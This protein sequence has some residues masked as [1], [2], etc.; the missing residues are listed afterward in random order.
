MT[1]QSLDTHP[2]AERIMVNMI[3]KASMSKRFRLVQSLTQSALW[4]SLHAWQERHQ[5][6]DEREAAIRYIS[7]SC[8]PA[9]A[10]SV[11]AA[12][13]RRECW[14]IQPADLVTAMLPALKIFD[15]L[16]IP[17]YLGGSV[18]SSLHGMQQLA[19]DIDLI[20]DLPE[21]QL[22]ALL[23]LLGHHYV[24]DIDMARQAMQERASFPLIHLDSLMKI[25][26]IL[27]RAGTF[28]TAMSQLAALYTLD[29]RYPPFKVAS[30]YEMILFKLQRYQHDERSRSDGMRDDAEWNDLMGMLKVQGPDLDL[31]LLEQWAE[32]LDAGNT[33]QRALT[34]AEL[35]DV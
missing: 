16:G 5:Q 13:G 9:L 4:S 17:S 28:D 33:W 29:E 6:A 8:G 32:T 1:T 35:A 10:R 14:H 25:D 26:V 7:Y 21:H 27:P 34:D 30:A 31:M 23:A 11:Q 12:L 15:E 2:A 24:L 22:P 18:A 3:R 19:Q 20:A